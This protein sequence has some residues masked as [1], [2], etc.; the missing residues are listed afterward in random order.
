M[1]TSGNER[2][3]MMSEKETKV[4]LKNP[5]IL[6]V[7][8]DDEWRLAVL[9]MGY[10][11]DQFF[12]E[13]F[14]P[15]WT[16]DQET[17]V[18]YPIAPV[19]YEIWEA[20]DDLEDILLTVPRDHSKTTSV[21]IKFL[22]RLLYLQERSILYIASKG[23]GEK[24]IGDVRRELE[25][26]ELIHA[27]FGVLVP[28]LRRKEFKR[29]KWRQRHLELLNGTEI[30]TLT[31]GQ[32]VRGS[33]PTLIGVDD[34][35]EFSD[36][37]NPVQANEFWQWFW[38]SLYN[39]LEPGGRMLAIG[40]VITENCFINRLRQEAAAK[41]VRVIDRSAL[42]LPKG[43]P[44]PHK[45][46]DLEYYFEHGKPLWPEKWSMEALRKRA[47]KI[48][49]RE[50]LLEYMNIPIPMHGTPVFDP[51]IEY[52][53]MEPVNNPGENEIHYFVSDEVL[54]TK[55]GFLGID[56]AKG[57]VTGDFQT[58]TVRDAEHNLLAELRATKP[59]DIVAKD[60][61]ELV[62][63]LANALIIP[64]NNFGESFIQSCREYPWFPKLYR[65]VTTDRIT[66][67]RTDIVG[68]TT[69]E[70]SKRRMIDFAH[71]AYR[72]NKTQVSQRLLLEIKKYY[73]DEQ[74]GMNALVPYHDDLV[75][76]DALAFQGIDSGL[77]S[78]F[79]F[80]Q[81]G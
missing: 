9:S 8:S 75:I 51:K 62:G 45:E 64:E 46:D 61:D 15:N 78:T 27:V 6:E 81:L 14:V 58:I 57:T 72:E 17:G 66:N 26:N 7:L 21:K 18:Q 32:S 19:H 4:L 37:K 77:N 38:T 69:T 79:F 60:V 29:Q 68:F 34:P 10:W 35:E 24:F 65:K 12:A 3:E 16:T 42:M 41:G 28:M 50:F 73:Y 11:D 71:K 5:S 67:K 31:K 59:Q 23:L 20:I 39:T 33:R 25:E 55:V 48:G 49:E 52:E 43:I 40:N 63:K 47:K 22:K 30:F 70:K 54:K 44:R 80:S 74:G 36:V 13:F 56:L 2:P 76:S 1:P 53:I